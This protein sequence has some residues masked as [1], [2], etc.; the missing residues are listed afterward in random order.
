[1]QYLVLHEKL[2]TEKLMAP[3]FS[4]ALERR[5]TGSADRGAY[6]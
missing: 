1:M 5:W 6:L 4:N 3:G 2:Q